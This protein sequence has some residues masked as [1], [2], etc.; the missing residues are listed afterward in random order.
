[1]LGDWEGVELGFS[2]TDG[3]ADGWIKVVGFAVMVGLADGAVLGL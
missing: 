3:E 2:E 1:M